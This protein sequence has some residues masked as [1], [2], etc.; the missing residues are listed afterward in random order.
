[1]KLFHAFVITSMLSVI[2]TT[3]NADD[4]GGRYTAYADSLPVFK[5]ADAV[6]ERPIRVTATSEDGKCHFTLSMVGYQQGE[7]P[8]YSLTGRIEQGACGGVP[9][10][11]GF[12]LGTVTYK[13][14]Q[15]VLDRFMQVVVLD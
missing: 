3:T 5:Y 11:K 4:S 15:V 2:S 8:N 9:V 12:A 1:M 10:L 6:A 14:G 13:E 7:M